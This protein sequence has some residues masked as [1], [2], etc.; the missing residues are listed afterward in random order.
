MITEEVTIS[1]Q[2]KF[3]KYIYCLW[4]AVVD[5]DYGKGD[6]SE[7]LCV[8]VSVVD[9]NPASIRYFTV[10]ETLPVAGFYAACATVFGLNSRRVTVSPDESYVP[11]ACLKSMRMDTEGTPI[12]LLFCKG[13]IFRLRLGASGVADFLMLRVEIADIR[14]NQEIASSGP[15][16]VVTSVVGWNLPANVFKTDE[17][18]YRFRMAS[19]KPRMGYGSEQST[20]N[21]LRFDF[22]STENKLRLL[23]APET[24]LPEVKKEL[25]QPLHFLLEAHKVYELK[26]ICE[27]IGAYN[28]SGT[29]KAS[30][31]WT[32]RDRMTERWLRDLLEHLSLGELQTLRSCALGE[33]EIQDTLSKQP[34]LLRW[35]LL[36]ALRDRYAYATELLNVLDKL[37]GTEEE[38]N[39]T[40]RSACRTALRACA[41]YY[42]VFTEEM[43]LRVLH[44]LLPELSH[45]VALKEL[46]LELD[47]D[48]DDLWY[49][50]K[51][52][53][54]SGW[55]IY[56]SNMVKAA[57]AN[58]ISTMNPHNEDTTYLPTWEEI[59][60][61][62]NNDMTQMERNLWKEVR[63]KAAEIFYDQWSFTVLLGMT[64]SGLGPDRII[65]GLNKEAGYRTYRRLS[66]DGLNAVL[67]DA[68]PDL[69][70]AGLGGFTRR[71]VPQQVLRMAREAKE[72]SRSNK[73]VEL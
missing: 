37:I 69:P 16:P 32:L 67:R 73:L 14:E 8:I 57:D 2:V 59:I 1:R 38:R 51:R 53:Q 28:N 29:S 3:I 48:G 18:C 72:M 21:E 15:V 19:R 55:M 56:N 26:L 13:D 12:S 4:Q 9:L 33:T 66:L 58:R 40:V 54:T 65:E 35:G 23:F 30:Y 70:V 50:L 36:T 49:D 60:Y 20:A 17:I 24:A 71:N 45:D 11:S 34:T 7:M 41:V 63:E 47:S 27:E 31:V 44:V 64:R 42:T 10:P 62:A 52:N 46:K 68:L 43:Y 5:G 25:G 6:D 61:A 39:M 22:R